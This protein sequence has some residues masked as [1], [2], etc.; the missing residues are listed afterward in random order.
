MFQIKPLCSISTVKSVTGVIC[1][2]SIFYVNVFLLE[3]ANFVIET[4]ILVSLKYLDVVTGFDTLS[5]TLQQ[6]HC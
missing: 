1:I 4:I 6:Y 3:M 2:Q 5:Q